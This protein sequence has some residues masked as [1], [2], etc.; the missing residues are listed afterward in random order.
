[1]PGDEKLSV[2]A[3]VATKQRIPGLGNGVLQDILFHARIHPKRKMDTL[4]V[5]EYEKLYG[6][7]KDTL[8]AMTVKGGRDTEK[9]LFGCNGGYKTILSS[10]TK[11]LPCPV[12]GGQI[13]KEAYLGGS[14]YYCPVCQ[15]LP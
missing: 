9:D 5:E 2:K 4:T 7:V 10:K 15:P 1:M 13:K 14:V 6:A 3:F 12:C 8:L 11:E